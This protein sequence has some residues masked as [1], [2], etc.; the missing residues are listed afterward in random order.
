[1]EKLQET[2]T[3]RIGPV[4]QFVLLCLFHL[5]FKEVDMNRI[6]LFRKCVYHK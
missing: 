2:R 1:M 4:D 5:D 3:E 6:H